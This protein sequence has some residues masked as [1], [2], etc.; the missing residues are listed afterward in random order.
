[1]RKLLVLFLFCIST[2][3]AQQPATVSRGVYTQAQGVRGQALYKERCATCHGDALQ[4]RIGPPL[5]G[6]DFTGNWNKEPLSELFNKI[7]K[8]MP[9][10]APGKLTGP[11]TADILAYILQTG[12][13][14]AGS[15][16]LGA[17]EAALKQIGWPAASAPR[18][19]QAAAGTAPA[20]PPAG[21]LASDARHSVSEFQH[22][23]YGSNARSG[24]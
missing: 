22:Y 5:T 19:V 2:L 23:I 8:T 21:N 13:F 7:A 9:Q 10:D 4:G 20:F 11:Q 14:P 12:K 18:P 16:E 15:A 24:G 1:M 6:D 17:S 3:Y